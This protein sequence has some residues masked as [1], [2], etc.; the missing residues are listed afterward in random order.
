MKNKDWVTE[1]I[2]VWPSDH[3]GVY[4]GWHRRHSHGALESKFHPT[5]YNA[6]GWGFV[7]D[8]VRPLVYPRMQMTVLINKYT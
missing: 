7:R 8:R 6:T 1:G 3:Y 4:A 2:L 5:K